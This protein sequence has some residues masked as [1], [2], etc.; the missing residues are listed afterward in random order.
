[1]I[2]SKFSTN[3]SDKD[4]LS[5]YKV[6]QQLMEDNG[7]LQVDTGFIRVRNFLANCVCEKY[8]KENER[9]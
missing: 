2:I 1:M 3:I 5:A 6:I 9:S 7:H 4:L 8:I